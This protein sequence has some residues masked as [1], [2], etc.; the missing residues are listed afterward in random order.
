M[1]GGGRREAVAAGRD[2]EGSMSVCQDGCGLDWWQ[3]H[4]VRVDI[5]EDFGS[6]GI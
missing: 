3:L 5:R 2:I 1:S 4:H 6:Q